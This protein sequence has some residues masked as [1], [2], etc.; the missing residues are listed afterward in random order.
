VLGKT[1]RRPAALVRGASPPPG[2][3]SVAVDVLM[4]PELDLFR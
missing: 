2:D 1:A 4:P 3:G